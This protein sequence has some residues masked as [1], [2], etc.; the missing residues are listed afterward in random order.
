MNILLAEDE[1]AIANVISKVLGETGNAVSIAPDG[2]TALQMA[3]SHTYDLYIFDIM[4]PGMNGLELCRTLRKSKDHKPVLLLT[5]LGSTENIVAG[6]DAGADDYLVKPFKVAEL[7]ARIKALM[8]RTAGGFAEEN[9][10]RMADLE[11]DL[12]ARLVTRAGNEVSL[13]STEYRMLEYFLKNPRK[14]ISRMD[15]L[16]NVW[17]VDFNMATN[18]VDVYV[19]YL[20]KKIDKEYEPKLIHTVIGMGYILKDT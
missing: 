5:A 13:T 16:E 18:V 1:P 7:M 8:R 10:L 19:N 3:L 14:V 15:L 11:L 17:G 9:K 12:E 6:L 4:L 2:N 20:R